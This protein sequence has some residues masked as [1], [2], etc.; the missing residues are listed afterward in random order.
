MDRWLC[1]AL[2]LSLWWL[3]PEHKYLLSLCYPCGVN[4]FGV[5]PAWSIVLPQPFPYLWN[6]G[7][8]TDLPTWE[9]SSFSAGMLR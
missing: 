2:G 9:K 8:S 7:L 4:P 6:P 1:A 5:L 3:P